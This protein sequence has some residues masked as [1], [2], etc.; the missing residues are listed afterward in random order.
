M[1]IQ[2]VATAAPHRYEQDALIAALLA[3]WTVQHPNTRRVEQLHRAVRV[4]GRNLA[5]PMD[6]YP[7]LTFGTAND[8]FIRVGTDIGAAAVSR[9][10]EQT[11][12]HPRDVD[13]IR[14]TTVTGVAAPSIDAR[15]CNRLGFRTDIKRAPTFGLG[16]VAGVAGIICTELVPLGW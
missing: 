15:L 1:L 12:L 14:F 16:C 2:A 13:A 10:P 4:G 3:Q 8:A 7:T 11:G 5:L 9:A 6:A